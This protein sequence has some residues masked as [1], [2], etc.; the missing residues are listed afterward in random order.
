MSKRN[1]VKIYSII[2]ANHGKR[3]QILCSK[4]TEAEIY[5]EFHSIL[6]NNRKEIVF[7]VRF[8][9]FYHTMLPS[10]HELI[11]I[12]CKDFGDSDV[13]K[14]RDNTGAFVN[15]QTDNEDW[16]VIDRAP[17]EVEETFW[18]YG[19]HPRLQR[20]TF[21]WIFENFI[22][23][24]SK[25]KYAFKTVQVYNNK[26]LI[27][28]GG[29]LEMVICKNKSDSVR[30]YNVLEEYAKKNKCKYVAFMG[31]IRNS[32]YKGDWIEKIKKLTNWNA[33]KISRLST[34]D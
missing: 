28:C 24:D 34:R 27:E 9:N 22:L 10:D 18:V 31:D 4:K 1:K 6:K 5:K 23:K 32:K 15:Y 29:K 11:I 3:K 13:N 17:Y 14:V 2:T 19:F 33:Q 20:K 21:M 8:N 26:I 25:D 7:P 30:F 16:I 12:K